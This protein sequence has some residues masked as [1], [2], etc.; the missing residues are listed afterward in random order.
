MTD[1]PS[2]ADMLEK[3]KFPGTDAAEVYFSGAKTLSV[4]YGGSSYKKKEISED[5]GY[6][7]RTIKGNRVGFS[8][9]NIPENFSRAAETA[10]RLSKYS[11]KTGFSFEPPPKKYPRMKTTDKRISGLPPGL[12]FTAVEEILEG[13]R[14]YAEP[15]RISVSFSEASESLANT[16]GLSASCC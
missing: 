4:E 16:E 2:P 15:T 10:V 14:K 7:V 3:T 1:F 11:Q 12:A 9:T 5:K 8:H 13:L 6:G